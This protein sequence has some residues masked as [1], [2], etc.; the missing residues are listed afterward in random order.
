[1]RV[2]VLEAGALQLGYLGCYGN[3]WVATPNLDRLAAEGVVFDRHYAD[4]LGVGPRSAWTGR[5]AFPA[6]GAESD[7]EPASFEPLRDLLQASGVGAHRVVAPGQSLE[8]TFAAALAALQRLPAHGHALVSV[9]LPTLG[10][11][12]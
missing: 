5:Y 6:A 4:A 2:L 9:S 3:D 1:M 11:P 10:P 12:W 8:A 7:P